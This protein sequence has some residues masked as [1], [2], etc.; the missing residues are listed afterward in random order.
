MVTT[1]KVQAG[2]FKNKKIP[3][4]DSIKG[5]TNFT[6]AL[7][8]K[9]VFAMIESHA[10]SGKLSLQN[11]IF[12]DLFAGSGQMGFEAVSRGFR[13]AHLFEIDKNRMNSLLKNLAPLAENLVFH[14]KDSLR[15]FDRIEKMEEDVLVYYLDPPYS[16]WEDNLKLFQWI[17]TIKIS[18][19][20][21][22]IYVQSPKE[23]KCGNFISRRFGNN[24]V[25]EIV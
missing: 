2:I 18:N 6:P 25:T 11:S 12:L 20:T 17:N 24:Y 4:V 23:L 22:I 19:P 3:M 15:Y 9:A 16:F 1:L 14:H 13:L 7:L 5:H 21:S 10:L 8:K